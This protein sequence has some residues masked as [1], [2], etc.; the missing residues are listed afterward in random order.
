MEFKEGNIVIIRET[1]EMGLVI[2]VGELYEVI[3]SDNKTYFLHSS[4]MQLAVLPYSNVISTLNTQ[5]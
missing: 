5:N 1:K 3:C 4:E 2:G